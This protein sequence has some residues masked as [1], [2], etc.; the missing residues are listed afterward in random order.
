[1]STRSAKQVPG[2][3][4]AVQVGQK[5]FLRHPSGADRVEYVAL[6]RVSAAHLGPWEPTPPDAAPLDDDET[7]DRLLETANR[8]ESQR[9]L[10]CVRTDGRI[11]GQ[12]SLNQIFRGPFQNAIAGYWMGEPFANQGL[13]TEALGLG[14]RHAF[15]PLKLHRVEANIIPRNTPS[16]RLVRRLG[17]RLEGLSPQ[18]LRINGRWEDHE[19]WAMTLEMWEHGRAHE[20]RGT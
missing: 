1:M 11:A 12:V 2:L 9:F 14:L 17:F 15:G 5:V 7:F 19:R 4:A 16:V 3:A 10:V 13:M 18:Y 6:R 20:R 8:P